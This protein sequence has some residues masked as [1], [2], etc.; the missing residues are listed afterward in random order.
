MNVAGL[1]SF[2]DY[3]GRPSHDLSN[4]AS[5]PDELNA[6]HARF[7]NNNTEPCTSA[8]TISEDWISPSK[9]D[10]SK[11][12]NMLN[13]YKARGTDRIP[14]YISVHT[15]TSWQ[16]SS[17]SFSTSLCHSLSSPRLK[18]TTIIPV[19]KNSNATCHNDYRLVALTS[20]IMKCFERLVWHTSPPSSQTP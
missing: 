8:P 20:E 10:V 2:T 17:R 5:L 6:F 12:L 3:K 9:A 14:G 4:D 13:T 19:P 11:V 16:A 7:D 18:L 1:H 15:Q